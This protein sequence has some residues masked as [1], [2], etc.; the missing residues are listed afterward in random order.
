MS[1]SQTLNNILYFLAG[2][3][4]T[5]LI[6][7]LVIGVQKKT[8]NADT[9]IQQSTRTAAE[10]PVAEAGEETE[11]VQVRT[12]VEKWQEGTISYN[13]KNYRYN[14]YLKTYVFMGI[15]TD[16]EIYNMDTSDTGYQS[17]AL[18]LIVADSSDQTL[19]VITINRNTMAVIERFTG[20]GTSMGKDIAQIC[21]QHAYGD[22]KKLSCAR[23]E[24][25]VSNLFYNIPIQGYISMNMGAVPG[26]NDAVGGVRVTVL[27]DLYYEKR[28]VSLK[29]GEEVVLNGQE[30]YCYLRGRDVDDFDSATERLRRQ[31]QY[32]S[33]F[34]IGLQNMEDAQTAINDT[35]NAIE[36]YTVTDIDFAALMSELLEYT[37]SEDDIY[38]VPGETIEGSTGYEEYIVDDEAFYDLVIRVFY[39]EV[40]ER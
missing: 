22:G 10:S 37:Y 23:V 36:A 27:D 38:T 14:N 6:G 2:A 28:G 32:I 1:V 13:G 16:D 11:L 26:L 30:A 35:Y 25:A 31:E 20:S 15:D 34:I 17:D 24:D 19:S 4:V 7:F 21:L 9:V 39:N 3:M 8:Q 33:S 40:E 5:L 12:D 18:F 29:K